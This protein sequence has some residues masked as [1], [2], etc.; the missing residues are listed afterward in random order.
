MSHPCLR[1]LLA[2]ACYD[3]FFDPD[4][5]TMPRRIVG[6]SGILGVSWLKRNNSTDFFPNVSKVEFPCIIYR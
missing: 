4:H 5:G 3:C 2:P 1:F 6:I